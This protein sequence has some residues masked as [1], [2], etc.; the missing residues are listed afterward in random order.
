METIASTGADLPLTDNANTRA[1]AWLTA[2]DLQRIHRTGTVGDEAGADWLMR[3]ASGLGGA[4]AVKRF[5][6]DRLDPIIHSDGSCYSMT[7]SARTRIVGGTVMPRALAVLKLTASL[8]V[9]GC[10]TGRSAGLAPFRIL[11]A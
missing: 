10:C 2:W 1:I 7:S 9:V 11:P 8:K 6:L 4:Q 3:E 5:S